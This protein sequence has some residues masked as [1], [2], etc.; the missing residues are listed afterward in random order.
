MKKGDIIIVG[1]IAAVMLTF[2]ALA[3]SISTV[4]TLCRYAVEEPVAKV[5]IIKVCRED[6][7]YEE[8]SYFANVKIISISDKEEFERTA[9]RIS[10][11]GTRANLR[12]KCEV[13]VGETYF[14]YADSSLRGGGIAG[15]WENF[16]FHHDQLEGRVGVALMVLMLL[17]LLAFLKKHGS[18]A[19][20][21]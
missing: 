4:V 18:K 9:S 15:W 3:W 10:Q 20:N 19:A 13:E 7:H 2:V 6:T 5:E 12:F 11:D 17:G 8:C 1:I 21:K 14:C 16:D